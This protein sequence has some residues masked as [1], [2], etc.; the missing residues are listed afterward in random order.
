MIATAAP[1]CHQPETLGAAA[2]DGTHALLRLAGESAGRV[3]VAAED[4]WTPTAAEDRWTPTA[5]SLRF[6]DRIAAPKEL[7]LLENAGHYPVEAPG[8]HQL[9]D[10]VAPVHHA[11]RALH[12]PRTGVDV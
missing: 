10:A 2:R 6:F 4:S 9:L 8:T 11:G 5:M 1:A 12:K 7:V 3:L